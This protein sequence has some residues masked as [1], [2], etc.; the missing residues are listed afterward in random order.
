M[1]NYGWDTSQLAYLGDDPETV[2]NISYKYNRA[3][4]SGEGTGANINDE[5]I[6]NLGGSSGN[7]AVSTPPRE[8]TITVMWNGQEDSFVLQP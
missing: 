2:G 3:G 5:G 4:G 6:V 8:V 7:G 1:D